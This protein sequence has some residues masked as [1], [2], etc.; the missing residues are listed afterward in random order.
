MTDFAVFVRTEDKNV[1]KVVVLAI[2]NVK[3][4]SSSEH[5]SVLYAILISTKHGSRN[6]CK[7]L[8]IPP[9]SSEPYRHAFLRIIPC[10]G[11]PRCLRHCNTD[12]SHNVCYDACHNV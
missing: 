7:V 5:F 1:N 4:F 8:F 2:G 3:S 9:D 12:A 11:L 6:V 10:M